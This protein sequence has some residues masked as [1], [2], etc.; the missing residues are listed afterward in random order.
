VSV[1][2]DA[3]GELT[4]GS[5]ARRP[6]I[7]R[8]NERPSPVRDSADSSKAISPIK[9]AVAA[10]VAGAL[11]VAAV[12]DLLQPVSGEV[13]VERVVNAV[14]NSA[15]RHLDAT[16]ASIVFPDVYPYDATNWR[17][18]G[19]VDRAVETRQ[20]ASA[21]AY[22]SAPPIERTD[23]VCLSCSRTAVPLLHGEAL[24]GVLCLEFAVPIYTRSAEQL[25][26]IE[27]HHRLLTN[28]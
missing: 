3:A 18:D 28:G 27:L 9:A 14:V 10:S 17:M 25:F 21:E 19:L 23:D 26:L 15:V 4:I 16:R 7:L 6:I 5:Q 1:V 24:I 12:I 2:M 22:S 8:A 13:V 20:M 11:D